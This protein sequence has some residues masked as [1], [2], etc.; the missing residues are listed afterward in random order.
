MRHL[1]SVLIAL[2][3]FVKY[4]NFENNISSMQNVALGHPNLRCDIKSGCNFMNSG[5]G[6]SAK[7]GLILGVIVSFLES[8]LKLDGSLGMD[9]CILR[10]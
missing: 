1:R 5:I 7:A 2:T 9:P 8:T 6:A 10:N 3:E 4:D